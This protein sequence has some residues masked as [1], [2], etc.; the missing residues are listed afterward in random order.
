MGD[1]EGDVSTFRS[2]VPAETKQTEPRKILANIYKTTDPLDPSKEQSSPT[3]TDASS[4]SK[5]ATPG[6]TQEECGDE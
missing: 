5:E 2:S 6:I 1:D 3:G 4:L